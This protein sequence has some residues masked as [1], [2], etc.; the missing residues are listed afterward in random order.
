MLEQNLSL[1]YTKLFHLARLQNANLSAG[2]IDEIVL[3][4][5]QN[6]KVKI[7]VFGKTQINL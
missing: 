7:K 6:T 3:V 5:K 4:G 1:V 2:E